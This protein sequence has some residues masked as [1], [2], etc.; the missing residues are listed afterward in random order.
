[1]SLQHSPLIRVAV[2]PVLRRLL[3]RHRPTALV[4]G[5]GKG[6]T[7]SLYHYLEQHPQVLSTK[8]KELDFFNGNLNYE[9]GLVH[10]HNQF[11][12]KLPFSKK[13]SFDISPGYLTA[14]KLAAPRIYKYN[15][16]IKLIALFRNPI[17]CA[18]SKWNMQKRYWAESKTFW[19]DYRKD[20][21]S[22]DQLSKAIPRGPDFGRDFVQDILEDLK[23]MKEGKYPQFPFIA[24]TCYF[25][26]L[27][28]YYKLFPCDHIRVFKSEA[29]FQDPARVLNEIESYVGIS[30]HD[31][32]QTDFDPVN[33]GNYED[34][35]SPEA[36]KLL[37]EIFEPEVR[38][39][40][41]LTKINF[42]WF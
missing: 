39:L 6:G 41:A 30:P 17:A 35:I 20:I 36:R 16:N 18:Y 9:K 15:P 42:A 11:R 19:L 32:S 37:M 23:W 22:A 24:P 12:L 21:W 3:G 8:G 38:S 40:E 28:E 13:V 29:F 26:H 27:Q 25:T 2:L 14:A 1:M 5:G 31:W 10:Y 33:V 7:T 4:I 34:E